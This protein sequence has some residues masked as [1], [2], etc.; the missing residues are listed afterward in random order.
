MKKVLYAIVLFIVGMLCF[1]QNV[2]A[3]G[4][5]TVTVKGD[6]L[7]E[8]STDWK[9]TCVISG[10]AKITNGKVR[11]TYDGSKLKLVSS[12]SGSLISNALPS[13][14]DPL[15]GNKQEGEVVLVFASSS[16]MDANGE[17]L[18]LTFRAV[19]GQLKN[20]DAITVSAATEELADN[21]ENISVTD[22]PLNVTVG[23]STDHT[24]GT[25]TDNGS[26]TASTESQTNSSGNSSG[27]ESQTNAG[28]ESPETSANAGTAGTSQG[29]STSGTTTG[30]QTSGNSSSSV[31]STQSETTQTVRSAKTGDDTNILRPLIIAVIALLVLAGGFMWSKKKK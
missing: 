31:S 20:G 26:N 10:D 29:S 25:G 14:N 13:I 3:A 1:R 9:V 22:V 15:S 8:N 2:M 12:A 24:S 5:A 6:I 28:I 4:A 18:Q 11:V 19:S 23:S 30:S 17:L 27:A 16:E 21:T 7:N